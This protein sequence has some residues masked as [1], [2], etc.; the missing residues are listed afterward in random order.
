MTAITK[1]RWMEAQVE[2]KAMHDNYSFDEGLGIWRDS[3]DKHVKILGMDY[4]VGPKTILEI[5]CAGFPGLY[6][7]DGYTKG[8]LVEPMPSDNLQRCLRE[9]PNLE[10]IQAPMEEAVLPEGIDEV[11]LFNVLQHVIDPDLI[12]KK[13]KEVAPVVRF[14]EPIDWPTCSFHPHTFTLEYFE[15]AF[16]KE[17]TKKYEGGS[18][19]AFH[20]AN[21][22]YGLWVNTEKHI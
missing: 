15:N 20:E 18:I 14:F 8:Y 5:G 6:L 11:W 3:F 13:C 22:A 10:L 16:G 1:Q 9:R 12:I 19:E 2:E 4:N 7:C 17:N 21:C